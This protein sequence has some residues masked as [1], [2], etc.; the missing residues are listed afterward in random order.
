LVRA[1]EASGA[2]DEVLAQAATALERKAEVRRKVRSA[3]AYPVAVVVL[4]GVVLMAMSIMVVPVFRDVYADLGGDLPWVTAVVL[5]FT[6]ILGRFAPLWVVAT[7]AT[8]VGVRRWKR[9]DDG[10]KRW[11]R[12]VLRLPL[13]GDLVRKSILAR[14]ARTLAVLTSAGVS[15]LDA[16]SIAAAVANNAVMSDVLD[17]CGQAVRRGEHLSSVLVADD[18]I[19]PLFAQVV[20]VGEESGDIAEMLTTA[21]EVYEAEVDATADGFS[22]VVEPLLVAGLGLVVGGL[23]L[24]LYLPM[25]RLVDLVQ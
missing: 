2:L 18:D 25:F 3:L 1:G 21:A 17:R 20:S 8:V 15:L 6:G 11:D 10:A 24:A 23:V 7:F 19:P 5:G 4:V 16:L 9:T 12:W 22:S 13:M 14:S